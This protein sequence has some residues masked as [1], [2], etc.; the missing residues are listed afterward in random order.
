MKLNENLIIAPIRASKSGQPGPMGPEGPKGE[1]GQDGQ[2]PN[3]SWIGTGL[4]FT[5]PDGSW[6]DIVNLKGEKGDSGA[7]NKIEVS[8]ETGSR[9]DLEV[10]KYVSSDGKV[11]YDPNDKSLSITGTEHSYQLDWAVNNESELPSGPSYTG[12]VV[13]VK[14]TSSYVHHDGT[15]WKSFELD[16]LTAEKLKDLLGDGEWISPTLNPTKDQVVLKSRVPFL[17]I[18]ETLDDLERVDKTE[19]KS[20]QT[21]AIVCHPDNITTT[22]HV[23]MTYVFHEG[24]WAPMTIAGKI[25]YATNSTLNPITKLSP[26]DNVTFLYDS[27]TKELTINSAGSGGGPTDLTKYVKGENV[28][29]KDPNNDWATVDW[30]EMG[31]TL[32]I[33]VAPPDFAKMNSVLLAGDNIRFEHDTTTDKLKIGAEFNVDTTPFVR[34]ASVRGNDGITP[35]WDSGSQSLGVGYNP[36]YADMAKLFEAG[37]GISFAKSATSEKFRITATGVWPDLTPYAKKVDIVIPDGYWGTQEISGEEVQLK[38]KPTADQIIEMFATSSDLSFSKDGDKVKF[39]TKEGRKRLYNTLAKSL[40][41][42]MPMLKA[43]SNIN[44]DLDDNART[45]TIESSVRDFGSDSVA[46]SSPLKSTYDS[47]SNVAT[48]SMDLGEFANF[49]DAASNVKVAYDTAT[50]KLSYT[51]DRS[52][53]PILAIKKDDEPSQSLGTLKIVN[54]KGNL[55]ITD[56]PDVPGKKLATLTVHDKYEVKG[57]ANKKDQQLTDLTMTADVDEQVLFLDGNMKLDLTKGYYCGRVKDKSAFPTKAIANKS[58]GFVEYATYDRQYMFDGTSWNE[59]H[60]VAGMILT[61]GTNVDLIKQIKNNSAVTINNGELTINQTGIVYKKSDG[62]DVGIHSL[63]VTGAGVNASIDAASGA[64]KLDIPGGGSAVQSPL[65]VKIQSPDGSVVDYADTREITILGDVAGITGADLDSGGK[66]IS[67]PVGILVETNTTAELLAGKYEV[68]KYKGKMVFGDSVTASL[69]KWYGCDGD[70]WFELTSKETIDGLTELL[71]RFSPNA[72]SSNSAESVKSKTGWYFVDKT[73]ID[74][75]EYTKDDTTKVR[76]DGFVMNITSGTD[77]IHQV[78]YPTVE[79]TTPQY[80]R[81]NAATSS[82]ADWQGIPTGG[83][84]GGTGGDVDAHNKAHDAHEAIILPAIVA[85][86]H[87]TWFDLSEGQTTTRL[88]GN[89]P[90]YLV[91]DSSG[92]AEIIDKPTGTDLYSVVIPRTG[93][94]NINWL[95]QITGAV[96]ANG[97]MNFKIMKNGTQIF[98]GDQSIATADKDFNAYDKKLMDQAFEAGDKISLMISYTGDSSWDDTK[99]KNARL[100]S[101]KNYLVIEHK[102]SKSGTAIADTFRRT[103]G[104]FVSQVGFESRVGPDHTVSSIPTIVEVTGSK[105]D[106]TVIAIK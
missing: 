39:N 101:F 50:N 83:G 68:A 16:K 19:C 5:K 55:L 84:G 18:F 78:F 10:I 35:L 21:M 98:N 24:T 89:I 62:S 9:S 80:R 34:G 4:R 23:D 8:D 94:Y 12:A 36:K 42:N 33:G 102:D 3:H 58:Y 76:V 90:L 63:E 91:S 93:N 54:A 97:N 53:I 81:W 7:G 73:A 38:I 72:T 31:G 13:F 82:W 22:P 40:G 65:K 69:R 61:D 104:G 87:C 60:P 30:D 52:I 106:T 28:K 99:K 1:P 46:A 14:S 11:K 25:F 79:F 2:T 47:T 66:K 75:P 48:V 43:G 105:Y 92:R 86:T 85:T 57:H 17:G 64:L 74:T 32:K 96:T 20:G 51:L 70:K 71:A 67:V 44:F 103:L 41:G 6:G 88:K 45:I 37:T 49:T 95:S 56:D 59:Y 15:D 100:D 27:T 26:G 29:P 77:K